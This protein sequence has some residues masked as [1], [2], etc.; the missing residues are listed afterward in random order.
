[1]IRSLLVFLFLALSFS[2]GVASELQSYW[3]S[4]FGY[5]IAYPSDWKIVSPGSSSENVS[6]SLSNEGKRS[7]IHVVS[8]RFSPQNR[9]LYRSISDIPNAK[10]ELSDIIRDEFHGISIQSGTTQLSNEPALWFTYSFVQRSLGHEVW[11]AAYQMSCLKNDVIFTITAKVWGL[12][13]D[14]A[15]RNYNGLW[16]TIERTLSTF[17][18]SR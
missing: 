8:Q 11:F 17:T 3:N 7:N 12:S 6:F 1:M 14:E 2:V 18:F 15:I 9:G 16:P 10:V 5:G 4:Q 13:Q